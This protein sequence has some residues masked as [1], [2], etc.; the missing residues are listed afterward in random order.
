MV[1]GGKR[2]VI[3]SGRPCEVMVYKE[4]NKKA[5]WV[6]VGDTNGE[7]IRVQYHSERSA[8]ER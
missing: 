6:A 4:P 3:V 5:V 1:V 8:L 7:S 2:T